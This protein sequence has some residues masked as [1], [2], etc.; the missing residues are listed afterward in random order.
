[1][2][3]LKID[4][5]KASIGLLIL[6]LL[7][8]MIAIAL[9][10]P[11]HM[12]MDTSMQLYEAHIG[13]SVSWNP[14]F[15]SALMKWVGGGEVAT[16]FIVLICSLFTYVSLGYV[17]TSILWSRA[18]TGNLKIGLWRIA[19]CALLLLNPVMFVY[20]GIVWKDVLFSS[21]MTAATALSFVAAVS[22][23][24]RG[25]PLALIA[26]VLLAVS[27]QIRQQGIFMVPVLLFVPIMAIVS[28][29][30]WSRE[31]QVLVTVAL[32]GIF[33]ISL[34]L[35]QSLVAN[36]ITGD[37]NKSNS[38]GFKYI[39]FFDIAGTI[40]LSQTK[41]EKLPVVIS[42]GQRTAIQHDYSSQRIDF[43]LS[44]PLVFAW[45]NKFTDEQRNQAWLSLIRYEP[46]AF[47][48]HK[49][50][51]FGT[52]LDLNGIQG[53]VPIYVGVNGNIDYLHSVGITNINSID[54]RDHFVYQLAARFL[55]W[56]LF[57]HWFYL[58]ALLGAFITITVNPLSVRLKAMCVVVS[59]ATG[60][61]YLSFLPTALSCDFRYLYGGIPLVTML[62]IVLLTGTLP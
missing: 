13:K 20:V 21:L 40:A 30:S 51:A 9:H 19:L 60:L 38:D 35:T 46:K 11:G 48:K 10:S 14:P 55:D 62:W 28:F 50:D 25:L 56:P 53:C 15:M 45:L 16:A 1:M 3:I 36:S 2:D 61:L 17:A 6:S 59:L 37:A 43:I 7:L 27:M 23:P 47:L 42:S 41:T 57:R 52:L 22:T 29:R 12:S 39:M 5:R 49:W 44:D 32:V 18:D 26:V 24:R 31:R 34:L 4:S 8:A 33:L 58:L 54:V